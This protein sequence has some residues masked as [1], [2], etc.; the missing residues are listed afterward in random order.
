VAV[1]MRPGETTD[2]PKECSTVWTDR[3]ACDNP[4]GDSYG[5]CSLEKA[6]AGARGVENAPVPSGVRK[7][8]RKRSNP[9][10]RYPVTVPAGLMPLGNNQI[11]HGG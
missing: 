7:K 9:S 5:C 4:W 3:N 1:A 2:S 8:P 10:L 6:F 11:Q